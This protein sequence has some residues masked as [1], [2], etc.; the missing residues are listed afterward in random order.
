[1]QSSLFDTLFRDDQ[2]NIVIGQP[3]NA[4]LLTW[5]GASLLQWVFP[6]EPLHSLMKIVALAAILLWAT[7]ELLTGVNYFRRGLGGLVLISV[8]GW[9][10]EQALEQMLP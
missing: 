4:S 5:I 9:Q 2:G 8:V 10:L 6:Q 7:Q 1:M 3:P